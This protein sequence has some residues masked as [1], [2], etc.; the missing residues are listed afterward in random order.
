MLSGLLFGFGP[1]EVLHLWQV[2][3]LVDLDVP[4]NRRGASGPCLGKPKFIKF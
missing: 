2:E 1:Y 3:F 4:Y